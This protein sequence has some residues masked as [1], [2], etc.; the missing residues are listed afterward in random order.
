MIDAIVLDLINFLPKKSRIRGEI[1]RGIAAAEGVTYTTIW[2]YAQR[3]K[4]DQPLCKP[5]RGRRFV[6]RKYRGMVRRT[7]RL[8]AQGLTGCQIARKLR[9]PRSTIYRWID[10]RD[11]NV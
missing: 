2:R 5:M 10:R 4:Q 9:I 8:K 11:I 7:L 3:R 6:H 1:I